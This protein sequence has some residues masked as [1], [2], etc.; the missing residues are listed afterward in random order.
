[1]S[2][3][4]AGEGGLRLGADVTGPQDGPPVVL[5]PGAGQTRHS[6]RRVASRIGEAG[7]RTLS[8]DLRGHGDS[9]RAADGD[10]TYPRLVADVFAV[11]DSLG[12]PAVLIGASLGGKVSLAAA[13][14]DHNG[15]IRG[16]VMVDTAPRTRPEGISRVARVL[17]GPGDGFASLQEAADHLAGAA[18]PADAAAVEKLRRTMRQD[19]AGRWRWHWDDRFFGRDHKLG[20]AAISDLEASARRVRVPTLLVYGDRSDVVD[21]TGVEALRA[22]IPYAEVQCI[23]GAGHMIVGDRN[24]AFGDALIGFLRRVAP[25]HLRM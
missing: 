13:G 3:T 12:Q 19:D 25:N 7:Y 14:Q 22:L 17:M 20:A 11:I 23:A 4:V 9:D 16:L 8:V 1:M 15:A 2:L 5:L 6:W 10:Y 24:D 18:G 21:A